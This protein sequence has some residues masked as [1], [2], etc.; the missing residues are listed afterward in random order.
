[1]NSEDRTHL[2]SQTHVGQ[3]APAFEVRGKGASGDHGE[4]RKE[5]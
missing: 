4:K 3:D 2:E 5:P 1:M